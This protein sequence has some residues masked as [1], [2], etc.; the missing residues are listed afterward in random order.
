MLSNYLKQKVRK[1]R[2]FLRNILLKKSNLKNYG[3]TSTILNL[4]SLKDIQKMVKSDE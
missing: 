3:D 4:S 2:D 1:L